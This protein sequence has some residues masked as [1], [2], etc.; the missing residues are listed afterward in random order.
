M[1]Q[2]RADSGGVVKGP[3]SSENGAKVREEVEVGGAEEKRKQLREGEGRGLKTD[4]RVEDEDRKEETGRG[5]FIETS[6]RS[7]LKRW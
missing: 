6:N 1:I 3:C 4:L 7:T 5:H 2:H